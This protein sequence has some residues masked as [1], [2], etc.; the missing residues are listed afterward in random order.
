[1]IDEK[2]M[3]EMHYRRNLD[4]IT[5]GGSF[6]PDLLTPAAEVDIL[7]IVCR[8]LDKYGLYITHPDREELREDFEEHISFDHLI[9]D[10]KKDRIL[11]SLDVEG[12]AF[13]FFDDRSEAEKFFSEIPDQSNGNPFYAATVHKR[14]IVLKEN[15]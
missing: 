13:L 2:G 6:G 7:G 4:R 5:D 10:K 11:I 1:M 8:E 9:S 15:T 3:Y 14:G 12:F